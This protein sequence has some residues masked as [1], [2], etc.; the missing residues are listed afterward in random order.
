MLRIAFTLAFCFKEKYSTKMQSG[1]LLFINDQVSSKELLSAFLTRVDA[2]LM[3]NDA[4]F[5]KAH[6][7]YHDLITNS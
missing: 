2:F 3:N 4:K 6:K 7:F 1:Y 5:V